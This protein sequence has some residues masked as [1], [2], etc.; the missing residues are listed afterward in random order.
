MRR[1]AH[2]PHGGHYPMMRGRSSSTKLPPQLRH[3]RRDRCRAHSGRRQDTRRSQWRNRTRRDDPALFRR[4]KDCAAW[5]KC[6]LPSM[7]VRLLF[8]ERVP[9]GVVGLITPWNFPV[10][11]PLWKAAPALVYGNTVVFKPSEHSPMT[12]Q[13]ITEVFH[14]VGLPAGV[15]NLVQGGRETGRSARRGHRHQW[16]FIHWIGRDR[17]GHRA[18]VRRTRLA[19]STGDGW[20]ESCRRSG[21]RESGSRRGI[22]RTGRHEIR[23]R[24]MHGNIPR[25]CHRKHRR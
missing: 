7:P 18:G 8:T 21:R 2:F 5:A 14:E 4:R 17:K 11:I 3:G 24:E 6:F 9:L 20:Q 22:D 19:I 13:M 25:H 16:H 15:F 10:A 1:G 23:R 12:A